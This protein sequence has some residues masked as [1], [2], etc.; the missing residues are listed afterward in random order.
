M[1]DMNWR[2]TYRKDDH[3]EVLYRKLDQAEAL[4]VSLYGE[5]GEGIRSQ[6][7]AL[8]ESLHWLLADLI[9]DAREALDSM[10]DER[11]KGVA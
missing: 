5:S 7:D 8:Q 2:R 11:R 1:S 10:S 6:N 3:K 9:T 4:A